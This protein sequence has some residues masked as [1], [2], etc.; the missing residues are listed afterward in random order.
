M[1]RVQQ[2]PDFLLGFLP[3]IALKGF[4]IY[5]RGILLAQARC[6]LN[7]AVNRIVVRD[8]TPDE[9]DDDGWRFCGS[10]V[11]SD[12]MRGTGLARG[13]NGRK[14][15]DTNANQRKHPPEYGRAN[16]IR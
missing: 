15:K 1:V 2:F 5:S 3:A 7:L 10:L 12:S 16:K 13:A 6:E 4:H 9:P 14:E 8:E 11:R